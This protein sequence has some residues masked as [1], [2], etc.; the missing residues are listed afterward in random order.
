MPYSPPTATDNVDGAVPVACTPAPGAGFPLGTTQVNCTA[1]DSSGNHSSAS[2]SVTVADKTP[3]TL[4]LPSPAAAEA[5]SGAGAAVAFS[6]SASDNVDPAPSVS[7]TPAS[8]SLFPLGSTTVSCKATD[9]SGNSSTGSFSVNVVD[10]TPPAFSNVPAGITVE[11]NGPGGSHVSYA[12]PS[13]NDLVDGPV[14][15]LCGPSSGSNFPLGTT[16]VTCNA[17]D[18][19]GNHG[20]T[21]F[22]VHVVDTTPPVLTIP[23]PITVYTTSS[24]GCPLPC[25]PVSRWTNSASAT[26]LVDPSPKVTSTGLPDVIPI[27]VNPVS[28]VATDAAGNHASATSTITVVYDPS[29]TFTPPT[30]PTHITP[31]PNVSGLSVKVGNGFVL[32][33]WTNPQSSDHI[34]IYRSLPT[35]TGVGTPIYT[36]PASKY[37]DTGLQNDTQYRYVVVTFDKAGNESVG[38]AILA[39]PSIPKLLAPLDGAIVKKPP[40]LKWQRQTGVAYWNVQIFLDTQAALSSDFA[41]HAVRILSAW[42]TSTQLLLHKTWRYNGRTYHLK[43]GIYRWFVWPGYGARSESK[44]GPLLGQSTFVV[45]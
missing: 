22:P 20:S 34:V 21:T 8:G 28:F 23:A 1:T 4:N 12:A 35:D 36:G 7:C 6:V 11:A 25:Y 31:P 41:T 32:L 40:V 24:P 27:G 3:P 17:S 45:R 5:T 2:F 16:T 37:R 44:Y 38:V 30:V 42:P 14:P 39:T 10:T 15:V 29:G 43:R 13:A 26:D 18:A 33:T 19:H 9:A